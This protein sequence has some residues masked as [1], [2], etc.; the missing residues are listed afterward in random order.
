[1]NRLAKEQL[2]GVSDKE[3]NT[4]LATLVFDAQGA[5][6]T[7]SKT[8][9]LSKMDKLRQDCLGYELYPN[10]IDVI[11]GFGMRLDYCNTPND[12]MPLAF[13]HGVSLLHFDD[14]SVAFS[15]FRHVDVFSDDICRCGGLEIG[16]DHVFI[17]KNTLRAIACCLILVL[18]EGK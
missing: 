4:A 8:V 1:M 17:N 9:T 7:I 18:Q 2:Q 10:A 12:I 16:A 11:C 5:P 15:R 14:V 6:Y 3:I 13:E